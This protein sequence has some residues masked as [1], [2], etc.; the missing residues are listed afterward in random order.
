MSGIEVKVKADTRELTAAMARLRKTG[1]DAAVQTAL[2][3]VGEVL[4]N[5][6][7]KRF[8]AQV[9]P[10]GR[11]W[12]PLNPAYL[13]TATDRDKTGRVITRGV[14]KGTKILQESGQ[15]FASIH[16]VVSTGQLQI[17]TNKIYAA[18]QQ[19]GATI[20][21][22]HGD[23]LIFW[24]GGRLVHARKVVLPAR[25]FLGLSA[26]DQKEALEAVEEVYDAGWSGAH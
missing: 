2:K 7:R 24:L 16:P 25:A 26:S 15:L 4:L 6:T 1:G 21:P 5:S 13:G 9:D 23:A 17:G 19:F 3:S 22:K 8:N 11:P 10:G 14:K 12:T 18:P 20:L